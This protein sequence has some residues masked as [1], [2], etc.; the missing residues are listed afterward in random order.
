MY[1]WR[2]VCPGRH[3]GQRPIM[4]VIQ[5]NQRYF[6]NITSYNR[7]TWLGS[8]AAAFGLNLLLF[9]M[10]PHLMD[11]SPPAPVIEKMIPQVH[12]TRT[13]RPE[14]EVKREMKPPKPPKRKPEATPRSTPRQATPKMTVPFELNPRLPGG[15]GALELPPMKMGLPAP[16]GNEGPFSE[17]DLDAPLSVLVRIPPVYPLR[18][19]RRGIEGWVRL[20]FVVN[21]SGNV[22]QVQILE[23][24]PAGVFEKSVRQ[25]VTRWRFEPGTIDGMPVRARMGTTIQ[26]KLE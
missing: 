12:I 26:F 25:C 18:A 10:M 21:T 1:P 24:E 7:L 11:T 17:G 19:R 5:N 16:A 3:S 2:P 22:V 6:E 4:P 8:A 20:S 9:L 13:R 15:P 14:P 23:A